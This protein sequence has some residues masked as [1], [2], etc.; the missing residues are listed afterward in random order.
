MPSGQ[1]PLNLSPLAADEPHL[2]RPD[3]VRYA[4]ERDLPVYRYLP[5]IH[6]HPVND[7]EGHSYRAPSEPEPDHSPWDPADWRSLEDYLY[8]VDLYNHHY[9][10]EAHEAWEGL[11]LAVRRGSRPHRYLQGL[12]KVAAALLKVR[13]AGLESHQLAGTQTLGPAGL[14]LLEGVRS[15]LSGQT[16][17]LAVGV[18]AEKTRYMGLD[19]PSFIVAVSDYL[20]PALGGRVFQV[21]QRVPFIVLEE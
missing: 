14:A 9:Y 20:Q 21:D 4:P 11:W 8:G 12:I 10:W 6:P 5:G 2:A 16:R 7:P 13:L 15:T 18:A 1:P 3:L 19:L 17:G